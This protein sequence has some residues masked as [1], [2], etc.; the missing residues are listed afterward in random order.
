MSDVRSVSTI[1]NYKTA[2]RSLERFLTIEGMSQAPLT[3]KIVVRY[4]HWLA[5]GGVS[6]NTRSCYLRSL[7]A[8][9]TG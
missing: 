5:E 6:S 8:S 7:R 1:G 3:R 9:T 2:L 4:D